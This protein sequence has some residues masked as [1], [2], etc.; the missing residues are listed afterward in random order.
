MKNRSLLLIVVI[1][2][3]IQS[4]SLPEK[5]IANFKDEIPVTFFFLLGVPLEINYSILMMWC[6]V[7][8]SISFYFSGY[9]SDIINNYGPYILVRNA[10]KTEWLLKTYLSIAVRLLA[11]VF[12]QT[13]I[14]ILI[15]YILK[16]DA[17]S[18]YNIPLIIKSVFI[19]YLSL[20]AIIILQTSL[21]LYLSPE[22]AML[23]INLYVILSILVKYLLYNHGANVVFSYFLIP[24]FANVLQTDLFNNNYFVIKYQYAFFT[25]SVLILITIVISI[26]T[27][28]RKD[29]Y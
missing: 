26:K 13:V 27:L 12:L 10:N 21:E 24:N 3:I 2:M 14:W 5:Y 17:L 22:I 1:T 6:L 20:L 16:Y 11:L 8:T 15:L 18:F 25:L 7:F 9:L 29:F 4:Y 28:K 19:Y 23:L